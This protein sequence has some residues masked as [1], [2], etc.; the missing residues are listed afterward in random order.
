MVVAVNRE[1][2]TRINNK[3]VAMEEAAS[4]VEV[5]MRTSSKVG[6]MVVDV[7]R[8][9]EVEDMKINN[10][11]VNTEGDANKV[12]SKV[13]MEASKNTAHNKTMAVAV[14]MVETMT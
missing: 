10:K 1:E 3:E 14:V 9:V 13:A 2:A 4:K 6:V 7:N 11:A 5:D 8:V 12:V